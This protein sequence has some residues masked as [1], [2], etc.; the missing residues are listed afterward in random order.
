MVMFPFE[1]IFE[2]TYFK[3]V[4]IFNHSLVA[5]KKGARQGFSIMLL[6]ENNFK[7]IESDKLLEKISITISDIELDQG[8][9]Y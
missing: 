5:L 2:E 4:V 1:E 3:S 9:R 6:V 7:N 8:S